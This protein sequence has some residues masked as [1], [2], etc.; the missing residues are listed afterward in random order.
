VPPVRPAAHRGTMITSQW[1]R[2]ETGEWV[3]HDAGAASDLLTVLHALGTS[4]D[5][6]PALRPPAPVVDDTT[7]GPD[8][9]DIPW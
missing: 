4:R 3:W 2:R 6:Q 5:W 1:K 9:P 7:W 8:T